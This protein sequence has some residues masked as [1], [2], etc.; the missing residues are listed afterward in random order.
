MAG[1]KIFQIKGMIKLV[2][3]AKI[4]KDVKPTR[5]YEICVLETPDD[6]LLLLKRNINEMER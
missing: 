6:F 4:I 2:V 5:R 1:Q 3:E